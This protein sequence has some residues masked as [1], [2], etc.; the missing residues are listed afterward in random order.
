M[1]VLLLDDDF[2]WD[3][4]ILKHF[5]NVMQLHPHLDLVGG[6]AGLDFSGLMHTVHE[7]LFL[8]K[9]PS[10][11]L[12]TFEL[13]TVQGNRGV[14]EGTSLPIL[15]PRDPGIDYP[16]PAFSDMGPPCVLVD[17]VPNFFLA[18]TDS[19]LKL[20]WDNN[21]KVARLR[22]ASDECGRRC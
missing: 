20:Q 5:A 15:T 17:F 21:L 12:Y 9:V 4:K 1:Y 3:P 16:E 13:T 6:R 14:L 18:R 11:L 19:L 22:E 8:V 7:T 10:Y 2:L